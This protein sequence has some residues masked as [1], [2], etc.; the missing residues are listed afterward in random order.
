MFYPFPR[1]SPLWWKSNCLNKK[2][3]GVFCLWTMQAICNTRQEPN[4]HLQ[5]FTELYTL[6]LGLS[7]YKDHSL[8][9]ANRRAFIQGK[10][11]GSGLIYHI[12][13]GPKGSQTYDRAQ[14]HRRKSDTMKLDSFVNNIHLPF[15]C[16]LLHRRHNMTWPL[17]NC[18]TMYWAQHTMLPPNP[19][20][21]KK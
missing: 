1:P 18:H 20:T 12:Y 5:S 2:P 17:V 7:M 6:A 3:H 4:N 14:I 8:V 13:I 11:C 9:S 15:F 10:P 21:I 16:Q 19:N